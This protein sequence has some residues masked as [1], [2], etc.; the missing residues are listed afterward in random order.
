V[1]LTTDDMRKQMGR[2]DEMERKVDDLY[3]LL[4]VQP[5]PVTTAT[6]PSKTASTAKLVAL[7]TGSSYHRSTCA[8]VVGKAN[9]TAVDARAIKARSLRPCR[10]CEPPAIKSR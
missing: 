7:P 6:A 1:L 10:V 8:L 5:D 2:L 9:A 3:S 4:V